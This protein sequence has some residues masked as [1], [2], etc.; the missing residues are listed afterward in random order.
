MR[1]M[2]A[3]FAILSLA[4]CAT[5]CPDAVPQRSDVTYSCADGSRLAVTF[6][7]AAGR[8]LVSE[9][10]GASL[11]LSAQISGSGF[12]YEGGGAQ[13]RGRGDELN[14]TSPAGGSTTCRAVG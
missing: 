8:A 14:W 4:A 11:D 12:R 2:S 3:G 13:I 7:R 9:D 6:D 5:P 1:A 10:G